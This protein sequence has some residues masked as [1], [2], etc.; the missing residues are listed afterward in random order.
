MAAIGLAGG[1]EE[2]EK[3]EHGKPKT[4]RHRDIAEVRREVFHDAT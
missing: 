3:A 4:A 1:G 2:I